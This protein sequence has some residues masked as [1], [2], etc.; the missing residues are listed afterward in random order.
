MPLGAKQKN[1]T[2]RPKDLFV[3]FL[4]IFLCNLIINLKIGF[5]NHCDR[6][7]RPSGDILFDQ[8][9]IARVFLDPV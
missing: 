9:I 1:R 2:K 5:V 6:K 8:E 4:M 3:L 7:M